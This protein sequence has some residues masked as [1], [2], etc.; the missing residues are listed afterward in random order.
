MNN[1]SSANKLGAMNQLIAIIQAR[2]SSRRLPSKVLQSL[3]GRPALGHVV[4]RCQTFAMQ[5]AVCTS[6]DASDD[7][8]AAWCA[9]ERIPVV[10][11]SLDD[12]FSRFRQTL[13]DPRV[14]RTEYF[15]RVTAD[16]PL[17][18]GKL[19]L[20]AL[21]IAVD[22]NADYVGFAPDSVARGL[23]VE[24]LKTQA[25][26]SI[27]ADSLSDY[28]REHVAP[29]LYNGAGDFKA[30]YV[31]GPEAFGRPEV[32]LTLDYPEDAAL[33]NA[34]LSIDP[35]MEAEEAVRRVLADPKLLAMNAD[36][37]QL[38]DNQQRV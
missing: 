33:L 16:C 37:K 2:M 4:A 27:D 32:R 34:L 24:I 1:L 7:A 22:Q 11:G 26:E 18:S 35:D 3:G 23:G 28:E 5:V 9:N 12:V 29:R 38:T 10:R 21:E 19:A 25:F 15:A 20:Q 36:C 31:R 14:E 17:V 30:V 8:I 13:H 6:T